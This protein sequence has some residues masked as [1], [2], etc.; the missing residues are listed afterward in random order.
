VSETSGAAVRDEDLRRLDRRAEG[1]RDEH[2]G[3][4]EPPPGGAQASQQ[5]AERQEERDV[6]RHVYRMDPGHQLKAAPAEVEGT[7]RDD[8]RHANEIAEQGKGQP[9]RAVTGILV[10]GRT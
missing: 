9:Q 1:E 7:E 3:P 2:R 4:S 5:K 6:Q 8:Q 10:A